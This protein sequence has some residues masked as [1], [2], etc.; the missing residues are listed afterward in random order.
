MCVCVCACVLGH[1]CVYLWGADGSG[2][3]GAAGTGSSLPLL[4]PRGNGPV[5]TQSGGGNGSLMSEEVKT[6]S[7]CQNV[8]KKKKKQVKTTRCD[9]HTVGQLDLEFLHV[10]PLD[11]LFSKIWPLTAPPNEQNS[12]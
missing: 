1:G 10:S 8:V 5:G 2:G 3:L 6:R 9:R 7:F 4:G 12:A 11:G